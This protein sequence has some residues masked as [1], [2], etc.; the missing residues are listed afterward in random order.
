MFL[1]ST[2]YCM[3]CTPSTLQQTITQISSFE[4]QKYTPGEGL[5]NFKNQVNIKIYKKKR[6]FYGNLSRE[7]LV[8]I[9]RRVLVELAIITN[10]SLAVNT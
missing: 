2:G 5:Q 4:K 7:V 10:Y 9:T 3:S 6:D 8:L 1:Q